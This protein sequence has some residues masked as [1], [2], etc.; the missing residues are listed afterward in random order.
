L[1]GICICLDVSKQRYFLVYHYGQ[2]DVFVYVYARSA[3]EIVRAYPELALADEDRYFASLSPSWAKQQKEAL[4]R[5]LTFDVDDQDAP[6]LKALRE[7][8]AWRQRRQQ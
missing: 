7:D 6:F 8:R 1:C 5:H 4:E 3:E 2:G